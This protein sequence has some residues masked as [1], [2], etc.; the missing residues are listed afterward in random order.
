MIKLCTGS[1]LDTMRR[2]Q[3]VIDD[4]VEGI[5]AFIYCTKWRSEQV[6]P[7]P[8]SLTDFERY[9]YSAPYKVKEWSSR[10][11]IIIIIII[12]I[13]IMIYIFI[14]CVWKG[15]VESTK[16]NHLKGDNKYMIY[17]SMIDNI[18]ICILLCNK[19]CLLAEHRELT[20]SFQY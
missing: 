18:I 12:I 2:Q 17:D 6:S 9:C 8:D 4:T 5:Y 14:H 10:N 20:V 3:L 15:E 1:V 19:Y 7:M 16:I 11:A 13:I